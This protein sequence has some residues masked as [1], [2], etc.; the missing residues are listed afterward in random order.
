MN[1]TRKHVIKHNK[2]Y[3]LFVFFV[4]VLLYWLKFTTLPVLS[5]TVKRGVVV[6]EVMGTGT[7]E[8][9]LEATISTEIS[10]LLTD[11]LV[12]Q[13]DMVKKEQILVRL[14]SDEL[15]Y[16]AAIAQADLEALQ[17][18]KERLL[19]DVDRALAVAV[20]SRRDHQ[21][22]REL[23]ANKTISDTDVEK[24]AEAL[25]IAEVE[26]V[27]TKLAVQETV[28]QIIVAENNYRYHRACFENTI[29]RAPFDG[30][31]IRR[32]RDPGDVVVSGRSIL[33]M[34]STDEMWVSAWV[35]ETEID[36][37]APGQNARVVFRA[38]PEKTYPGTVIRLGLETD[39]ETREFLVDVGVK[40]LPSNWSVGQRAEVYIKTA[41]RGNV[42]V[43][44]AKQ[45][46]KD[47][48]RIGVF[49]EQ[50]GRAAWRP[51][52]LG[53]S[54]RNGV[55]ILKGLDPGEK[56]IAPARKSEK[57]TASKR[58]KIIEP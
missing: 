3:I 48:G 57:L 55:E 7:L 4:A 20:Q 1:A 15:K 6:A 26:L 2:K 41:S 10:G 28:K 13:G 14:D 34:A 33:Y 25:K 49:I 56:V 18:K 9:K 12:D 43:V 19:A 47:K 21:R 36:R 24:S 27:I 45:L 40:R 52:T 58:I 8:P 17:T 44:P 31:I 30:I 51:V 29:I 23:F 39:R 37:L 16:Q 42:V 38:E 22:N 5:Y 32:D 53:L 54:G 50:K 46:F 35:D 11:V